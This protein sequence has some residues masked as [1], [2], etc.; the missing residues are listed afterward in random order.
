[1]YI[2]YKIH[3]FICIYLYMNIYININIFTY[4]QARGFIPDE[5][6]DPW[7]ATFTFST[8]QV[9]SHVN[10]TIMYYIIRFIIE[11]V[12]Q[13]NTQNHESSANTVY[14]LITEILMRVNVE[15]RFCNPLPCHKFNLEIIIIIII[16]VRLIVQIRLRPLLGLIRIYIYT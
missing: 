8:N 10:V 7:V 6:F 11:E 1:V 5:S 2:Y 13:F 3:I 9:S 16:R 4:I 15:S 12:M 14:V